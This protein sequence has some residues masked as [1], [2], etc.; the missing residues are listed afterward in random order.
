M[1]RVIK[2]TESDLIK[3][4]K[5]VISEQTENGPV[6]PK[7]SVLKVDEDVINHFRKFNVDFKKEETPEDFLGKLNKSNVGINAFHITSEGWKF[8]IEPVF[9]N[10]PLKKSN[11]RLSFEPF[12]KEN[13]KYMFRVTRSF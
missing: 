6:I 13:G 9:V 4:V 11:M 8:P 12:N 10:V 7:N 1:K 3:I 5:R 2:L